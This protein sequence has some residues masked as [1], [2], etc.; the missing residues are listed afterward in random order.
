[1]FEPPAFLWD[2]MN[3][4]EEGSPPAPLA[5]RSRG[6]PHADLQGRGGLL[7]R[8]DRC[9]LSTRRD[10]LEVSAFLASARLIIGARD[11]GLGAAVRGVQCCPSRPVVIA[12]WNRYLR[13]GLPKWDL[14][15]V[16]DVSW[17][18]KRWSTTECLV[19][20]GNASCLAAWPGRMDEGTG[21]RPHRR[22]F[23][24]PCVGPFVR[25]RPLV[26]LPQHH[27]RTR[28]LSGRRAPVLKENPTV[29]SRVCVCV[30]VYCVICCTH[31]LGR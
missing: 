12:G 26:M 22:N 27:L 31:L 24:A 29:P 17:R 7:F 18:T 10:S 13:N 28:V 6:P 20:V 9:F 4:G 21:Q 1:M 5:A 3:H 19:R 15:A 8:C 25:P 23:R 2:R 11:G 14:P 16:F 30:C